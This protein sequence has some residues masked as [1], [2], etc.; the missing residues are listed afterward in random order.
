MTHPGIAC[1]RCGSF[2][3]QALACADGKMLAIICEDCS[4][5]V[6]TPV[7]DAVDAA[8]VEETQPSTYLRDIAPIVT[9]SEDEALEYCVANV[10]ATVKDGNY[11]KAVERVLVGKG[12]RSLDGWELCR[13]SRRE[14]GLDLASGFNETAVLA[15]TDASKHAFEPHFRLY[16]EGEFRRFMA[17][18]VIRWIDAQ[19]GVPESL[20]EVMGGPKRKRDDLH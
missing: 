6:L 15:W 10:L 18:R 9:S 8:T 7:P 20:D 5:C 14:L 1:P 11:A 12:Y 3:T 17:V 2:K 16:E 4:S 13:W 19:G